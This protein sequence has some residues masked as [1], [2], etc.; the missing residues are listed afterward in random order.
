MNKKR[1]LHPSESIIIVLHDETQNTNINAIRIIVIIVINT[2]PKS[3]EKKHITKKDSTMHNNE[4]EILLYSLDDF[5]S[6][7]SS[8]TQTKYRKCLQRN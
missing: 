3:K 7:M 8:F 1:M 4:I 6:I 2:L 5:I